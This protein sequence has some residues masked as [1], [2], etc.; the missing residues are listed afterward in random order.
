MP[1][2][3]FT[4]SS[5]DLETLL[6]ALGELHIKEKQRLDGLLK[7]S[8]DDRLHLTEGTKAALRKWVASI[9]TLRGTLRNASVE[10]L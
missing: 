10:S 2:H 3:T 6:I 5:D 7:L 9:D 8:E 4:L 1:S